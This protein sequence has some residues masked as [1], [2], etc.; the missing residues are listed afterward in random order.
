MRHGRADNPRGA[1]RALACRRRVCGQRARPSGDGSAPQRSAS[2][3]L[4]KEK[5]QRLPGQCCTGHCGFLPCAG[6]RL[7]LTHA[8]VPLVTH[9]LLCW[10]AVEEP[11]FC[12]AL[13]FWRSDAHSR[14]AWPFGALGAFKAMFSGT[15]LLE[16]TD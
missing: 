6:T 7:L 3:V 11:E 13:W 15:L 12:S 5:R 14:S 16:G 2:L 1:G 4:L 10:S 8:M 9:R